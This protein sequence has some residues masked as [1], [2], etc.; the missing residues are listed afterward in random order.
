MVYFDDTL[1][2][3]DDD[4]KILRDE[5]VDLR[6]QVATLQ[7]GFDEAASSMLRLRDEDEG[8]AIVG[9]VKREDGFSM[10]I[11]KDV[12]KKSEAQSIGNPLLKHGF[13]L[14]FDPIFSR[15][16]KLTTEDGTDL[17]PRHQKKVDNA[18]V[19]E[20]LFSSEGYEALE[21]TCYNAGNLFV[22][23][24][25]VTGDILRIPFSEI[26][27]RAVEPDFPARTAYYQ[28]SHT[29]Q[30]FDGTT[31]N[32]IEWYPVVEWWKA[33][34]DTIDKIAN[35]P[36]NHDWTIIDQRVNVP[37]TGHWGIPDVFAALPYAWAYSEYIR[38]AASLLKA[39]N[40]IAW[41]VVGKSKAQAQNAGVQLAGQRKTGGIASMT[42]GTDLAAMPKAGQVDMADGMSL[43][44]MAASALGVSTNALLTVSS[45]G[46]ATAAAALDGPTVAMARSRQDRWV[47]FYERVFIAMGIENVTINFPKI[48]EDPIYRTVASLATGRATGAIWADE[49]REAFLEALSLDSNHTEAPPV[50]EYAQAQNALGFISAVSGAAADEA[51]GKADPL[52]KQG[53]AGV[54]GKLGST[55]NAGLRKQD[56]KAKGGTQT[57]LIG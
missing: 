20:I 52:S 12:A 35:E 57:D 13:D 19:Q 50:D 34:S 42:A 5:T 45:G 54:A 44:A 43:A 39:L 49:Y 38:D 15:G 16:F 4:V 23:Y 47:R 21:K 33:G 9:Q 32:I 14:R 22:A 41:K 46:T 53:N 1:G 30:N 56:N 25:R 7:E 2:F 11:V 3:I 31:E 51:Q 28:Y 8:W 40:K 26:T 6:A 36:V 10:Q 48:T 55:D 29:K 17:K 27:N 24:N 37:T 18:T